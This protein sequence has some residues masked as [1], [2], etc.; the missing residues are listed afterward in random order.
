MNDTT[1]KLLANILLV[2]IGVLCIT[3]YF[4]QN[5]LLS[6]IWGILVSLIVRWAWDRDSDKPKHKRKRGE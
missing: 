1:Q 6:A 2:S 3:V 4:G 5:I